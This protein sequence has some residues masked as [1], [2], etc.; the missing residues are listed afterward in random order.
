MNFNGAVNIT[1]LGGSDNIG[2]TCDGS[3][4]N[5]AGKPCLLLPTVLRIISI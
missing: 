1:V 4:I 2:I 5:A 3:T